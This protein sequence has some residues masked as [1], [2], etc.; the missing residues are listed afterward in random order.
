MEHTV[1]KENNF[2]FFFDKRGFYYLYVREGEDFV[3]DDVEMVVQFINSSCNL[4]RAPFLVV[5]GY[6]CTFAEG[7]L[8][9]FATLPTRFSTADALVIDTYAHKL[10][11]NFYMC[12][13]QPATPTEI[14]KT[15]EKG[16]EWIQQ[17][18]D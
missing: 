8:E 3:L 2:D 10:M 9:I 17:Y 4:V 6:G 16:L 14:F 18:L 15:K 7:V 12:H 5:L 13:Y 1:L 11:V